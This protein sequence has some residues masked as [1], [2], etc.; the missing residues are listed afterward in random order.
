METDKMLEWVEFVAT[1]FQKNHEGWV[2]RRGAKGIKHIR[3]VSDNQGYDHW[4]KRAKRMIRDCNPVEYFWPKG[5]IRRMFP[6]ERSLSAY[7]RNFRVSYEVHWK[8]D[9]NLPDGTINGIITHWSEDGEY[10]A[11]FQPRVGMK[12]L[13]FI[14]DNPED[15][16]AQA[17]VAEMKACVELSWPEENSED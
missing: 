7:L 17:I 14:K 11:A 2:Y 16:Y 1:K 5:Q 6:R 8:L 4:K 15:P 12:V 9:R 10:I 3:Y 13:E